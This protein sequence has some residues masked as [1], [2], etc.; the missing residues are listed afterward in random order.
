M[1]SIDR[2][3]RT[4]LDELEVRDP[5]LAEEIKTRMFVFEDIVTLDHRAIQRVI[6]DV[7]NQDLIMALKV[8]SEEVKDLVFENM[9]QRM[10][11]TIRDEIEY[12]G[13]VRLKDVEEAQMRIV[14]TIRRLEDMGEIVI[15]RGGGDDIIV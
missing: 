8:A 2:P 1:V 5:E 14:G 10:A 15:A 6:R 3:E 7:E 11:E 9:S 4:I 13:P 12:M